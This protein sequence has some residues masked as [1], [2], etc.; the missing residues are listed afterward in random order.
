VL[1]GKSVRR[2]VAN[3]FALAV[4]GGALLLAAPL[5]ALNFTPAAAKTSN[6]PPNL[7]A[8][9][10]LSSSAQVRA[11]PAD[12][13]HII[14][15]GVSTSVA[16]AVAAVA[17]ATSRE[18]AAD[19][20]VVSPSGSTVESHNGTMVTRGADGST[21]T[22]YPPDAQGRRK[23]VA[24]SASGTVA[25]SY[26]DANDMRVDAAN[27]ASRAHDRTVGALIEAKVVGVTPEY[28]A[29]MRAAAPRLANLEFNEFSGLRAVGVSPEF[30]RGLV[31]AGFPSISAEEL[32]QARAVGLTGDYVSAMRAA[33]IRGDIDDF[34]QLRAVGV[35]PSFAARVKAS[36][37][38][39]SS[40][41]ELVQLRALDI[42][43][44]PAPP[45]PP[46]PPREHSHRGRAAAS[47]PNWNMPDSDDG[48]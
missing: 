44:I 5:A 41:D 27:R 16:T 40:A 6:F 24:R 3:S 20:R 11:V 14:A 38:R 25:V 12:L 13:P 8:A 23:M 47:P 43:H 39:V 9:N 32:M 17:P 35:D 46:A 2:P 48:G 10:H 42:G 31:A 28:I 19:V 33:G 36:G 4:F 22:I 21:V 45:R 18:Q 1:D 30:A 34:V 29:A 7:L 26:A 15:Q 37:V